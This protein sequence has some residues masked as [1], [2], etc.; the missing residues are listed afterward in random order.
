[1]KKGLFFVNN[2]AQEQVDVSCCFSTLENLLL[3]S[4]YW[5]YYLV[6]FAFPLVIFFL[7][8]H[9]CVGQHFPGICMQG[10]CIVL[11]IFP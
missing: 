2:R 8:Y 3:F 10:F 11:Q 9:I 5:K 7:Q 4:Y 1:M 6:G